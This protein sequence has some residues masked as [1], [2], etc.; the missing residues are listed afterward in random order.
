MPSFRE[1][2]ADWLKQIS[3]GNID[4]DLV[5]SSLGDVDIKSLTSEK[6]QECLSDLYDNAKLRG[7][8]F[9]SY[10][11]F[12]VSICQYAFDNGYTSEIPKI[13]YRKAPKANLYNP[14]DQKAMELLLS[15][16]D[17]TPV[18]TI[19]RLAW[20]C[21]LGRNEITF[22]QWQQVDLKIMQIVLPDRKVPLT[23]KM[24]LH[25]RHLHEQNALL[26]EY[27]LMSQRETAPMAEQS[28]SALV[29][30]ALD[31]YG[32]INVRL[33]DLR[34]DFIIQA[35][36]KNTWEHV[37]YI[38]GVDLPSIQ[39]HYFPYVG[40]DAKIREDHKLQITQSVRN[41]LYDFM[42]SEGASMVGVAL[43]FVMQMGIPVSVLPL[44]TW[45]IIDFNKST[46][47]F[48][49]R[50]IIVPEDFLHALQ[51]AKIASSGEYNNI[52]LNEN[53]RKP[54]DSIF[55]QKA[56]QQSLIRSGIKGITLP[57]LQNDYWKQHFEEL[58]VFVDTEI[59][60]SYKAKNS[61]IYSVQ[62]SFPLAFFR[63]QHE[64]L[65]KYLTDNYSADY[66]TLKVILNITEKELSLM[67]K[68]C[69]AEG[70]IARV[71]LRYFL[72]GTIVQ[73]E[74]Q[75]DLILN[76]VEKHQPVSSS[77]LTKLLGLVERRQIFW[78]IDPLL[79][80]GDLIRVSRN[81]YC[82]PGYDGN[83]VIT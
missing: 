73:R 59:P 24:V 71:G 62:K 7:V 48:I 20:Y 22:L 2:A 42:E 51:N 28:V 70:K 23:N 18:G 30:K 69:Q 83:L 66:K 47:T 44:M 35:L 67:L 45:D 58:N 32:Q 29:R 57:V 53:K 72:A 65:I 4:C 25:L 50:T 39:E 49:D 6:I 46:A 77:E 54:T 21:G 60:N 1:V 19:L 56:V 61:E 75:K 80:S 82:I 81:K 13:G 12:I 63:R 74:K 31:N 26:S 76:Y 17:C 3:S 40:R 34:S 36:T 41:T 10:E 38:S 55:I 14:P 27:V 68:A 43:R 33:S 64:D 15:H 52:I 37:S 11:K 16:E 5:F 9:A 79:K 8:I 78:I